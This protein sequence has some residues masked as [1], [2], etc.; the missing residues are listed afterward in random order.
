MNPAHTLLTDSFKINSNI[1]PYLFLVLPSS[2]FPPGFPTYI[3]YKFL[4]AR[5]RATCPSHH[6]I[7]YFISL[8]I[9]GEAYTL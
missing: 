6:I 1:I 8:T 4:I 3:L 2:L 9:F 7:L 5:M